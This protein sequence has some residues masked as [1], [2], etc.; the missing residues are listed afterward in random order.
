MSGSVPRTQ[1]ALGTEVYAFIHSLRGKALDP[2]QRHR[3]RREHRENQNHKLEVR[4]AIR[5]KSL[6][7]S[8]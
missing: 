5:S 1:H 7:F 8:L 2:T 4:Y 6:S 3:E